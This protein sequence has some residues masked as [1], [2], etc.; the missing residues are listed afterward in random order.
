MTGIAQA[1]STNWWTQ[2]L[3]T[4]EMSTLWRLSSMRNSVT[5][6]I[7]WSQKKNWNA[8]QSLSAKAVQYASQTTRTWMCKRTSSIFGLSA[9]LNQSMSNRY[10]GSAKKTKSCSRSTTSPKMWKKT[11]KIINTQDVVILLARDGLAITN[12]SSYWVNMLTMIRFI[13]HLKNY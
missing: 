8:I 9:L 1:Q 11:H 7:S 10:T 6:L 2:M 3:I 13:F 12:Q 5:Q 4:M